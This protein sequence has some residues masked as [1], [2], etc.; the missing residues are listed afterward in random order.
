VLNKRLINNG[1]ML[2]YT[3]IV[4]NNYAINSMHI[5]IACI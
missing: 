1:R 4:N 2:L 3:I 5:L